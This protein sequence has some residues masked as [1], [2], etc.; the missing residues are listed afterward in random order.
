MKCGAKNSDVSWQVEY[1]T[2]AAYWNYAPKSKA[3][4]NPGPPESFLTASPQSTHATLLQRK[5]ATRERGPFKH[6]ES[7]LK[8]TLQ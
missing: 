4:E 7:V 3:I 2:T 8:Y 5:L 1:F 6:F